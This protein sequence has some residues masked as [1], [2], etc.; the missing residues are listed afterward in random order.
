MSSDY[1]PLIKKKG[2]NG[3]VKKN[4]SGTK[5]FRNTCNIHGNVE[6]DMQE[7]IHEANKIKIRWTLTQKR[8]TT[9]QI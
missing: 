2:N 3:T 9:S 4:L 8:N 7:K 6:I 5:M 1:V